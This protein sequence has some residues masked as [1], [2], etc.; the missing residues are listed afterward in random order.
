M[1]NYVL[2]INERNLAGKSLIAYLKSL[3]KTSNFI[4]VMPQ[5]AEKEMNRLDE[6]IEDIKMGRVTSYENYE[7]YEQA[8]HKMLGY[9]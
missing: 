6:A 3:S 5:Q 7:E 4:E 8:V 9:V 1:T 2:R